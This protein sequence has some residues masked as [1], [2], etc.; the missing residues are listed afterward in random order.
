M[1]LTVKEAIELKN[2]FDANMRQFAFQVTE[3]CNMKCS[4]CYKN[5][6][7]LDTDI[8]KEIIDK[9]FA[10]IDD[11]WCV[12][13]TGGEPTLRIDLVEYIIK[14]AKK[15]GCITY[16]ETNGLFSKDVLKRLIKTKI[17]IISIGVN[18]YHIVSDEVQRNITALENKKVKSKVHINSIKGNK[19][20]YELNIKTFVVK[21]LLTR[22]GREKIG[23]KE[24]FNFSTCSNEGITVW[25]DG[26][27]AP[28]CAKGKNVCKTFNINEFNTEIIKKYFCIENRRI[29]IS[30]KNNLRYSYCEKN[31]FDDDENK[32]KQVIDPVN[33]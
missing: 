18:D 22:D 30:D 11:S 16:I 12:T 19:M 1:I 5:S 7:E 23:T 31:M 29:Y 10:F 27:I 9:A 33:Y 2:K 13:I 14:K 4:C 3:R 26:T 32:K 24:L 17:D 25:P 8:T 6:G 21:D 20:P 28:F 15:L